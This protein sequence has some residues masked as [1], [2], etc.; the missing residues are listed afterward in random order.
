MTVA[1]TPSQGGVE[2]PP[3]G[4]VRARREAT[5]WRALTHSAGVRADVEL[6]KV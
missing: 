3:R 2:G 4:A 5:A 6:S 1:L